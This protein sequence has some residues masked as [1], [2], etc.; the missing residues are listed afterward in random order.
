MTFINAEGLHIDTDEARYGF[1]NFHRRNLID[2]IVEYVTHQRAQSD[3]ILELQGPNKIGKEFV[4]RAAAYNA[5]NK[6]FPAA[7]GAINLRGYAPQGQTLKDY[8]EY[9]KRSCPTGQKGKLQQI[10]SQLKDQLQN[11]DS[12]L[13]NIASIGI[14]LSTNLPGDIVVSLAK[15]IL[16]PTGSEKNYRIARNESE[17]FFEFLR[18]ASAGQILMIYVGGEEHTN[19]ILDS[20]L[21]EA[22]K[23][24]PNLTLAFGIEADV[25]HPKYDVLT[26]TQFQV[27]PYSEQELPKL[28]G[29]KLG[30]CEFSSDFLKAIHVISEGLPVHLTATFFELLDSEVLVKD[31]H[32]VWRVS[33]E[34][35]KKQELGRILH[36]KAFYLPIKTLLE[37]LEQQGEF[38]SVKDLDQF[39]RISSLCGGHIPFDAITRYLEIPDERID[40]LEDLLSEALVDVNGNPILNYLGKT[41]PDFGSI[42]IYR[43]ANELMPLVIQDAGRGTPFLGIAQGFYKFLKQYLPIHSRGVALLH[44]SVAKEVGETS[45]QELLEL[46]LNWWVDQIY[47]QALKVSLIRQCN[48]NA[49]DAETL[50]DLAVRVENLWP[51]WRTHVFLEAYGEQTQ[52]MPYERR[53]IW[54]KHLSRSFV[55]NREVS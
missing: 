19:A 20:W 2:Q 39:L 54:L 17:Q 40:Q 21:L 38:S 46:S 53:P 51:P 1:L 31:P 35:E 26:P 55:K 5:T 24:L 30:Q 23:R 15:K 25:Q 49:L 43:F 44:L 22:V 13:S 12:T 33:T 29:E 9:L 4:L 11:T 27:T 18:E 45:D 52:S 8:L 42:E 48:E 6:N 41:L 32:N 7:V 16:F 14:A 34:E 36:N 37:K 28:L 50:W 10:T 3:G 47:T